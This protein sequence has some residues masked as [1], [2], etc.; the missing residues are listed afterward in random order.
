MSAQEVTTK[1]SEVQT[2]NKSSIL[3]ETTE[4]YTIYIKQQ[5]DELHKEQLLTMNVSNRNTSLNKTIS[6][7]STEI[8]TASDLSPNHMGSCLE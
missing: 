6:M 4:I 1:A 8:T 2:W 3:Y 7:L 5:K